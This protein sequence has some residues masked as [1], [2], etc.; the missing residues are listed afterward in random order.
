MC[1]RKIWHKITGVGKCGKSDTNISLKFRYT[2]YKLEML[3]SYAC[4]S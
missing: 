4:V 1:D 2:V 3:V